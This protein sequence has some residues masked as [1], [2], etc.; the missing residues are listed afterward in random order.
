M[1]RPISRE[2]GRLGVAWTIETVP[3]SI[4]DSLVYGL[5]HPSRILG[6]LRQGFKGQYGAEMEGPITR[7]IHPAASFV[8]VGPGDYFLVAA[9]AGSVCLPTM[10]ISDALIAFVVWRN[11]KR[12]REDGPCP[13]SKKSTPTTPAST[14][15]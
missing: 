11:R 14:T 4:P 15:S 9:T 6:G 3:T 2:R 5:S 10:V 8:P 13:P 12:R 1:L 7:V